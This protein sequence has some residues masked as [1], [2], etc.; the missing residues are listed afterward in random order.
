MLQGLRQPLS[1]SPTHTH[2]SPLFSNVV[3]DRVK[4]TFTSFVVINTLSPNHSSSHLPILNKN[5]DNPKS[6]D[7]L[8]N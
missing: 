1:P 5:H 3:S 4:D 6:K 8:K 2:L 7:A